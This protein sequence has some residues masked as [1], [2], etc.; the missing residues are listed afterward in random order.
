MSEGC[1]AEHRDWDHPDPELVDLVRED[2]EKRLRSYASTPLDVD[3]HANIEA[4]LREGG[5]RDRQIV[6]VVQNGVDAARAEP[7]GGRVEVVLTADA[8]YVANDG[9]PLTRA[10]L[11]SLLHSHLSGKRH[12]E[13][14]RFGLGFKSV[15]GVSDHI[16]L[17]S[18]SVSME[19]DEA[20]SRREIGRV[21]V[22]DPDRPVPV[23]R[24]PSLVEARRVLAGD[25]RARAISGWASTI[26][27]ARLSSPDAYERLRREIDT[28]PAEFALFAGTSLRLS[29]GHDTGQRW[30]VASRLA[31]G[32]FELSTDGGTSRW[33]VLTER[34][35]LTEP[36]ALADAGELHSRPYYDL[37][38][39]VSE[40]G[41]DRGSFWAWFPLLQEPAP[42]PGVVN[43]PW[44]TND[45]RSNV[46]PGPFNDALMQAMAGL[47]T[48]SLP[49]LS[50]TE[51]PA[52]ALD[53]LPR[54]DVGGNTAASR[55]AAPL[56]ELAR[57]AAI[58]PNGTGRL[59]PAK[60]LRLPPDVS[61][62]CLELWN[63]LAPDAAR[64]VYVHPACA[65]RD[66]LGR[67]KALA[68]D[69]PP[70]D[71]VAWL[72][73]AA[74]PERAADVLGLVAAVSEGKLTQVDRSALRQARVVL[75]AHGSLIAASRACLTE[76]AELPDGYTA[77]HSSLLVDPAS[78]RVL[79]GVLGVRELSVEQWRDALQHALQ[80]A[81]LEPRSWGVFWSLVRRASREAAERFLREN[82]TRVRV[83]AANGA[84]R[85][86]S[87]MLCVGDLVTHGDAADAKNGVFVASPAL[88]EGL[89]WAL[90]ALGVSATPS[91]G[92]ACSAMHETALWKKFHEAEVK[93]FQRGVAGHGERPQPAKLAVLAPDRV[94]SPLDPLASG[95]HTFRDRLTRWLLERLDE[96]HGPAVFGHLTR[97]DAYPR[98]RA[99]HP[100]SWILEAHG[101]LIVAERPLKVGDLLPFHAE[102]WVASLLGESVADRLA[103]VEA[104]FHDALPE[105]EAVTDLWPDV[106][107]LALEPL[108]D[109]ASRGA[110]YATAA[111]WGH[112][113]AEL[114]VGEHLVAV[115]EVAVVE[116]DPRELAFRDGVVLLPLP[117]AALDAF[118]GAGARRLDAVAPPSWVPA[119]E[120]VSAEEFDPM[121]GLLLSPS[122][123]ADLVLQPVRDLHRAF[124]GR[125]VPMSTWRD[126]HEVMI[127][128][129]R[130]DELER[131]RRGEG[132][133]AVVS[134]LDPRWLSTPP[135]EAVAR[136]LSDDA[137]RRRAEVAAGADLPGR[138]LRA[139]DG[140][141]RL[142]HHCLQPEV[143][144]LLARSTA[145]PHQTAT[146]VLTTHGPS[147]L[148]VLSAALDARGLQP[149]RRWGTAAAAAFAESLGF[150]A[151]FG[152]SFELRREP[153]VDVDGPVPLG[154][155][156][157]F[158][159]RVRAQV[160]AVLKG[161]DR[162]RLLIN[163]PTGAGKTRVAV[164]TLIE[165]LKDRV[166]ESPILWIAQ[167]DEL[168]EQA[169]VCFKEVWAN[170]GSP[171]TR[172]RIA[173]LWG[174]ISRQIDRN[175]SPQ[176]VVASIQ[177]LANRFDREDFSWLADA[178][179]V[180]IDEAHHA[181][182]KS[183]TAL[184]NWLDR[185]DR[186]AEP[187]I[188]GLTATAFRGFDES[189][190][191]R[192][193]NRFDAR[194]VPHDQT[195]TDVMRELQ[196]LEVLARVRLVLLETGV[197]VSFTEE[198][199]AHIDRFSEIPA[200]ALQRL[201]NNDDRNATIVEAILDQ[202]AHAR[203]LVFALSVR[204]AR[205]LAAELT[206][207]GRTAASVDASTAT[208]TR[209]HLIGAFRSGS[210]P[211]LVNFGV[212]TTGFDAP[213]T[214]VI[215]IARPTFSPNLYQQMIGRGLRGPANGG[216][217][218]CELV[219]VQDNFGRYRD[220]LA[221]HH[222][223]DLFTNTERP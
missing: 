193:A 37:S 206:L 127:D 168:C 22:V 51:D 47:I 159:R 93:R 182:T 75:D 160:L 205:T 187:P 2:P 90:E 20:H 189:E 100:M 174:G 207:R 91:R 14:G 16:V 181:T 110:L 126:G 17:L 31:D 11:E 211:V 194:L 200:S 74:T 169:V 179:V 191:R 103:R 210:V 102:P 69:P 1:V 24:I 49:E 63:R 204:H 135:S 113:P 6:E 151:S 21:V 106:F 50:T 8:L 203:I 18:R 30:F 146:L 119:G 68:G 112:V 157:D 12:E 81:A 184:V 188:I 144:E 115:R 166:V 23:M 198:E 219:T 39:A 201:A 125:S 147:T 33:R 139:V 57:D 192:L 124:A 26:V 175:A 83:G 172:L 162:R 41:R 86:A 118:V 44:K 58:V 76:A 212:L 92:L 98:S 133:R 105:P 7:G 101:V 223:R 43:A 140:D 15:L 190:T 55:L 13:I 72:E 85:P 104:G 130:F 89:E 122:A 29:L 177:T 131:L 180:V 45:D 142:L 132:F 197:E 183:Y 154:E 48:R 143:I 213:M 196:V 66:R 32:R 108:L 149:P 136:W 71:L 54:R 137:P 116:G 121:L 150:P 128:L 52:A 195:P 215:L 3:E 62:E 96:R 59:A 25:P 56:R 60:A 148:Q 114:R 221:F 222:F 95:S 10:G 40:D 199:A 67:L 141:V 107:A 171:R 5:Y 27:I 73:A 87:S 185:E 167:S 4:R 217:P 120:A 97:G 84:W 134:A 158:Q 35:A 218:L 129:D 53:Y 42:V 156:H 28:F 161:G 79:E 216:K 202:P 19:F 152:G 64:S 123:P 65:K 164:Q 34:I 173:R 214:D 153:T 80:A 70:T 78:R 9:E 165:G 88:Y 36:S 186:E 117:P 46:L 145:T 111:S 178:G 208:P 138:L 109:D 176:V 94:A 82:A 209:R 61:A 99:T 220:Q 77:V 155:L 170:F 163:L 38:W